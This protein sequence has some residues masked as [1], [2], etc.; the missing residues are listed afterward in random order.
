MTR[1]GSWGLDEVL[2]EQHEVMIH[3]SE[4]EIW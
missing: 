2:R 1:T 3:V 4:L